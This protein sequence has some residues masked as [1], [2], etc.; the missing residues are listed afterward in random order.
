MT[1]IPYW[2]SSA[3]LS[4]FLLGKSRYSSIC[5]FLIVLDY[6]QCV[7][8][9]FQV[10]IAF[11]LAALFIWRN[12]R[13]RL[14]RLFANRIL[15]HR[16]AAWPER[17]FFAAKRDARAYQSTAVDNKGT[18]FALLEYRSIPSAPSHSCG[19]DSWLVCLVRKKSRAKNR[20]GWNAPLLCRTEH[21]LLFRLAQ[22]I[23]A[24]WGADLIKM[25]CAWKSQ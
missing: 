2:H 5:L 3:V 9:P 8:A 18:F 13:T 17:F 20:C 12:N 14:F 4:L 19:A 21:H 11:A 22:T 24:A 6:C 10:S 15:K 23:I 7:S 1:W 16:C 25:I